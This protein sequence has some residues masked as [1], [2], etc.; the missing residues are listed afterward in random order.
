MFT[1]PTVR[2]IDVGWDAACVE[3]GKAHHDLWDALMG[4]DLVL[5]SI[6]YDTGLDDYGEHLLKHTKLLTEVQSYCE[7]SGARWMNMDYLD[8][9]RWGHY[10]VQDFKATQ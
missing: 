4:I 2:T 7:T 3:K 10:D 8:T 1:H 9:R 6:R 5:F